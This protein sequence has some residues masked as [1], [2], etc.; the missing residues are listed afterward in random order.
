MIPP[1]RHDEAKHGAMSHEQGVGATNSAAVFE[2]RDTIASWDE[3]YYHPIAERFYDKLFS[4]MLRAMDV[5]EGVT[6]L[7]AGCG[8]GVY[9]VRAARA[10]LNVCAI[11]ISKTMLD[12][13]RDR[14]ASAGLSSRVNFRQE[15]LTHLSLPDA[16][17]D[18]VFC[19]GVL[20]HIFNVESALDE[21]A[22][23]IRPGGR[24]ALYITNS[25]ALDYKLE[26]VV[27]LVKRRPLPQR[28]GRYGQG[29][30]YDFHG[31]KLWL[32]RFDVELIEQELRQRGF[33]LS[34][35]LGGHFSEIQRRF[36]GPARRGLLHLNNM[37]F[38]AGLLSP[39]F[40]VTNLLIF[41]KR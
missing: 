35:R 12:E 39:R 25:R 37:L 27:R 10:G 9:S 14:V 18:A 38:D 21:L 20:I 1:L 33:V 29:F 11:D 4:L 40:A 28:A 5:K 3:D 6:I 13:A 32:W 16:S 41:Q 31:E 30:E 15:D 19:W 8:P 23:I 17:F 2:T 24:L 36:S 22:R 34:R 26:S 7:D